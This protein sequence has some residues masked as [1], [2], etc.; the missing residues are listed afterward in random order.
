[1]KAYFIQLMLG[2]GFLASTSFYPMYAHTAEHVSL[3]LDAAERAFGKIAAAT[4]RG[5][6]ARQLIGRPAAAGFERLN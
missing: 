6:L 4:K 5:D 2:D 3:Y 1:M